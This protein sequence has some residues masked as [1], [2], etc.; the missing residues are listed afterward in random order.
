[1]TFKFQLYFNENF[2][3]FIEVKKHAMKIKPIFARNQEAN[4]TL[5]K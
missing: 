4:N 2:Y 1:M 3:F 5:P